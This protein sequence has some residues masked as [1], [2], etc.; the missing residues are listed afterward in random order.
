MID[1][2][3]VIAAG[4]PRRAQ[5]PRRRPGRSRRSRP[6]PTTSAD[7]REHPRGLRRGDEERSHSDG[8]AGHGLDRRSRRR[9]VRPSGASMRKASSWT[10]WR[11]GGPASTRCSSRITGHVG[12]GR[13]ARRRR[14]KRSDGMSTAS[15]RS[16]RIGRPV[17][18]RH[19]HADDRSPEP[20]AHQGDARTAGRDDDPAAHVP[21]P[22]RLRLRRSDRRLAAAS[23]CSSR[24]RGSWCRASRSCRSRPR[25]RSNVDFQRGVID[26]FR[27]L[28]IARSAVIGGR[29]AGRRRPRSPGAS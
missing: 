4:T 1:H 19:E 13:R 18:H 29:I 17:Q 2:G 15:R 7:D 16:P 5:G 6:I 10:T 20:A 25:S 22:V 8:Q 23:T 14:P 11:C 12:R 26:R 28:P 27:S 3:R 9:S 21:R 24:C